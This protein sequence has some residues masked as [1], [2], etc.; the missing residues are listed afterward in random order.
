MIIARTSVLPA[1]VMALALYPAALQAA[2][3]TGG[4]DTITADAGL[5]QKLLR[6]GQTQTVYLRIGIRGIKQEETR[7]RTPGN[8]ALVIDRSGSMQGQKIAKAREAAKMAI[9]RMDNSDHASIVIFDHQ[10][11]ALVPARRVQHP[12]YFHSAI[13]HIRARGRTAIYGSIEEAVRQ[14]NRYKSA[15]RFNRII[16]LSDGL[17]NVGP[18]K[19][20]DFQKLGARLGNNG[21]SVSTI[22]LGKRYN[23][24]LMAQL[25]GASDGNHAFARTAGD[26]VKIFDQ[27][28]DEVL[29]VS[30]QDVEIIIRTRDGV[31]PLRSLGRKSTINGKEVRMR[32]NQVYGTAS[33]AL[34][35]ALKI[36]ASRIDRN[37]PRADV[38]IR[39]Q[40]P[41]GSQRHLMRAVTARYSDSGA[42]VRKSHEPK[43]MESVI[44]LQARE[45]ARQAVTLRD[46]GKVEEA[47]K[48]LRDNAI[49]LEKDSRRYDVKSKRMQ[50]IIKSNRAAAASIADRKRWV[51]TRKAIREGLSN[52]QGSSVKY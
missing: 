28:F 22:G 47:R 14:I 38:S 20:D 12:D 11:E 15:K 18:A 5:S 3:A 10:I 23:E 27:E 50:Q 6:N 51:T 44:E 8:I 19:A 30:G 21:I 17:A 31:T 45:R 16:L 25:A 2:G 49:A 34:L 48:V 29:S 13:D 52:R 33:H 43:I 39:Y 9:N 4:R 41:Q 7:N 24:D 35:V 37:A 40:P 46:A 1:A 26:L 32:L 36:D 42:E